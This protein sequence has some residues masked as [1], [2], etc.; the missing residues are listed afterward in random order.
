MRTSASP[1]GAPDH[2]R[3][4]DAS[5][6]GVIGGGP[7]GSFFCCFLLDMAQRAGLPLQV[8]LYEPRDFRRP[9]PQGCNMCGGIVSESLVQNLA[10]EG[11]NLR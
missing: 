6:V 7:A 8:D 2:L 4:V 3:L 5:T 9:G 11:I 10:M 1:G